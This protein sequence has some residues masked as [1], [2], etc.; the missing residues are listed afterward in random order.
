MDDLLPRRK[1]AKRPHSEPF[2]AIAAETTRANVPF[3][4]VNPGP[5]CDFAGTDGAETGW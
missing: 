5:N 3:H 2:F 1:G 4:C